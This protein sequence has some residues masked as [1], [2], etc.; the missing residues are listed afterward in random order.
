M[1]IFDPRAIEAGIGLVSALVGARLLRVQDRRELE[2]RFISPQE[3]HRLMAERR[4]LVFDIREALDL[5]GESEVIMGA[6]WIAPE[7]LIRNPSLIPRD[8]DSVIYC[9]CPS[10]E[11]GIKI[12]RKA[13]SMR[14]SRMRLLK[15]GLDAWKAS[16]YETVPYTRAFHLNTLRA[17]R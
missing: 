3:L 11:T 1:T 14:F 15:G 16:G 6:E 7:A 17:A 9:T 10:D 8:H 4:V 12:M 5:L 2:R 13:L